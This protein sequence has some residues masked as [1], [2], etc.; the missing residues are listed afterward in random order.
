MPDTVYLEAKPGDLIT[1]E[2][3]NEIQKRIHQDVVDTTQKA[4]S[5]V[6]DVNHAKDSDTLDGKTAKQLADEI[7]TR[8]VQEVHLQ[9]GYRQI[10]TVLTYDPGKQAQDQAYHVIDHKLALE[11]LVDLYRLDYFPVVYRRD[12]QTFSGWATFYLFHTSEKKIRF[13]GGSDGKT[14]LSIEIQPTNGPAY[15]IAW[16]TLLDRYK[17]AYDDDKSLSDLVTDFWS[18]FLADP[19]TGFDEDQYGHS[20]W[21]ER[22]C[23]DN[24]TVRDLKRSGE[25]DDIWFKMVPERISSFP[26]MPQAATISPA[27]TPQGLPVDRVLGAPTLVQVTHFDFDTLGLR[28]LTPADYS[29]IPTG[30]DPLLPLGKAFP[31]LANELKVMVLLK[32]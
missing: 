20:P 11:P 26:P 1:A 29:N 17:V 16:K 23:C 27:G 3:W 4:V 10:F 31:D 18:A 5:G 9:S 12:E 21:F 30:P 28:M 13:I 25:W 24:R 2:N 22:C 7:V 14:S 19:N 8:A 15:K 6:T 32:V